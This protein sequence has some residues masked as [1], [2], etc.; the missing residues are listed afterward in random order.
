MDA[1]SAFAAYQA[2]ARLIVSPHFNPELV[3]DVR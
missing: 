2:G 1:P 3:V